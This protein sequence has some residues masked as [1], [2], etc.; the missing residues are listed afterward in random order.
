MNDSI[1]SSA[2]WLLLIHQIP[3]KP[4]YVRVKLR[5]RL[6][7]LGAVPVKRSVYALPST[8]QAREDFEWLARE[9]AADGGEAALCEATF[10]D[11]D[12]EQRLVTA[13]RQTAAT[14]YQEIAATSRGGSADLE[15]LTRRLHEVAAQDRFSAEGRADAEAALDALTSRLSQP[16]VRMEIPEKPIGRTW[17]TRAGV[18]VDRI[19]SAW[20]I[21]RFIDPE[22]RF[23][24]V[25]PRQFRPE[26][27]ELRFDMF[28]G[29]FTHD[30]DLC[31]FETLCR[32][33]KL[34]ERALKAIGEIVHDIDCKDDKY[35]RPEAAGVQ[36]VLDGIVRASKTDDERLTRGGALFD[37]LYTQLQKGRP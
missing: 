20:L 31:T 7:R 9:I 26:P 24:F 21:R 14:A 1:E 27:G 18:Y 5:R 34:A 33:F 16:E 15:R 10:V 36:L 23:R 28:D 12:T 30:R 8:D 6:H 17:V 29:E 35:G 22:S 11:G 37:D 2:H 19:A 25:A 13:C 32:H 4:D 3:P